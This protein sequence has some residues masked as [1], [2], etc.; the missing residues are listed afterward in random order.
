[1]TNN[2]E[3]GFEEAVRSAAT[4][5]MIGEDA[6]GKLAGKRVLPAE[7]L[8]RTFVTP[9]HLN[10]RF[11]VRY[12]RTE[13]APY[14]PAVI[15]IRPAVR[16]EGDLWA[17]FTNGICL[18]MDEEVAEFLEAHSGD[19]EMHVLYHSEPGRRPARECATP[20]GLCKE[21]A[22]ENSK[23]IDDWYKMKRGQQELANKSAGFDKDVDVDYY[24][25]RANPN[26]RRQ[27]KSPEVMSEIERQVQAG[28]N[29][30]RERADGIT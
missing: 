14:N 12:G 28:Q 23:E 10:G 15:G 11:L 6:A 7:N 29:A 13:E 2:T 19:P 18:T 4:A 5:T 27:G 1:M 17:K 26:P 16:R 30:A 8:G 20:V 24:F 9:T 21:R 22:P 3:P 25:L